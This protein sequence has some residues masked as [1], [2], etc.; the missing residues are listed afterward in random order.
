MTTTTS[1]VALLTELPQR[2]VAEPMEATILEQLQQHLQLETQASY[3]YWELSGRFAARELRGFARYLQHESDSER[4]HAASFID[5]L[6]DRGQTF[7]LGTQ[8]PFQSDCPTV[9]SVFEAIFAMERDV[10]SSL[11]QIHALAEGTGD[12]RTAVFL[13]PLIVSQITAEGDAA[14]LVGRLQ[15]AAGNPAALLLLDQE[16]LDGKES[17][18]RLSEDASS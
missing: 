12:G 13:E 18:H 5:Y 6:N 2:N 4:E 1:A 7:Q 15:I 3:H 14:H 16:L 11:Q 10:T 17:P 8:L 9:L